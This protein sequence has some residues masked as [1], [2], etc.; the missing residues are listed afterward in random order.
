MSENKV[1]IRLPASVSLP[2]DLPYAVEASSSADEFD[3][4]PIGPPPTVYIKAPEQIEVVLRDQ[5]RE[6]LERD[7]PMILRLSDPQLLSNHLLVELIV[8]NDPSSLFIEIGDE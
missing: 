1:Y 8:E 5:V 4:P 6:R 7:E 2:S 3:F